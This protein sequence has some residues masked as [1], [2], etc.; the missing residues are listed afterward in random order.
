MK[1]VLV[2]QRIYEC[3]VVVDFPEGSTWGDALRYDPAKLEL[4][5]SDFD[6]VESPII[7]EVRRYDEET[8]YVEEVPYIP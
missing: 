4:G 3:E 1:Y 7:E 5:F 6:M 8:G 2:V